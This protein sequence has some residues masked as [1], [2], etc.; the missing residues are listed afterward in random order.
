VL[1]CAS[2]NHCDGDHNDQ[3][4]TKNHKN[5]DCYDFNMASRLIEYSVSF[6]CLSTKSHS[7]RASGHGNRCDVAHWV[8]FSLPFRYTSR[9]EEANAMSGMVE[10]CRAMIEY[11][12]DAFDWN[13]T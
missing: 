10:A 1:R 2:P 8:E 13:A 9:A 5:T 11:Q 6:R 3:T 7:L 4:A 12:A